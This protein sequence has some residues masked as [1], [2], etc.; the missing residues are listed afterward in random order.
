MMEMTSWH[1]GPFRLD[2]EGDLF[3]LTIGGHVEVIS[4][5]RKTVKDKIAELQAGLTKLEKEA[6]KA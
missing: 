5:D 1:V 6:L 4:R 2:R 3:T